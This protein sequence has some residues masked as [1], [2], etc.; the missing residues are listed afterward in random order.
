MEKNRIDKSGGNKQVAGLAEAHCLQV[1]CS[2]PCCWDAENRCAKGIIRHTP[3]APVKRCSL[4]EVELPSLSIVNVSEW[5]GQRRPQYRADTE[6]SLNDFPCVSF[7]KQKMD[8]DMRADLCFLRSSVSFPGI[9]TNQANT[10]VK[11]N[12]VLIDCSEMPRCPVL[13]WNPN[14]HHV[15]QWLNQNKFKSPNVAIKEMICPTFSTPSNGTGEGSINW[16]VQRRQIN[17]RKKV[18]YCKWQDKRGRNSTL[19]GAGTPQT[20]KDHWMGIGF[21]PIPKINSQPRPRRLLFKDTGCGSLDQKLPSL[22]TPNP[23][24]SNSPSP[25]LSLSLESMK[26]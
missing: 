12:T 10:V 25:A 17:L 13:M 21:N 24:H 14:P 8:S 3:A 23:N 4:R 26:C 16:Q 11:L 1:L 9:S 5:V 6:T 7:T 22:T 19:E 18:H 20:A 2:H 15:P